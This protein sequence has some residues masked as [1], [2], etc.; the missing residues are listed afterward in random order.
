[1]K[2]N[3]VFQRPSP[4]INLGNGRY[5]YNFNVEESTRTS[6]SGEEIP[7]FDYD[8]VEI[9]GIPNY[10]KTVSAVIRNKYT[11]DKEIALINNYNRYKLASTSDRDPEDLNE[12][13]AYLAEVEEIKAMVKADVIAAGYEID[14]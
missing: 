14:D 13:K 12:Y 11:L 3:C 1:M 10:S 8:T 5:H 7:N 6:E 9:V 4:F 2:S